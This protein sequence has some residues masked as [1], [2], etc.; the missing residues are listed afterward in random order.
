MAAALGQRREYTREQLVQLKKGKDEMNLAEFPIAA[1]SNRVSDSV[2]TLTFEEDVF[3]PETGGV[4]TRR[5]TVT[6]SDKYGLPTALDDEVIVGLLQLTKL[7]GFEKREVS[8]SRYELIG[9][10][11]WREEGRSYKRIDESLKR[12]LG[13]TLYYEKAWYDNEEKSWVDE[14]FHLLED[15]SLY[16]AERYRRRR[17]QQLPLPLSSFS[18]STVVFRSFQ[19]GFLKNLDL[20]VYLSLSTATAKRAYRFLDKR[21]Y[22]KR[23][24]EMDLKRFAFDRVGLS[25]SFEKHV[26]KTKEKLRPAIQEL[27]EIGFLVPMPEDQRYRK[28]RRGE[29]V[30]VLVRSDE[31]AK[32]VTATSGAGQGGLEKELADRGVTPLAA[33]ELVAGFPEQSVRQK[34]EVFDWIREQNRGQRMKNPGGYLAESIRKDYLPPDGFETKAE[35]TARKKAKAEKE[36]RLAAAEQKKKAEET[37]RWQSENRRVDAYLDSLSVVERETLEQTAMTSA[38]PFVRQMHDRARRDGDESSVERYRSTI[39]RN[40]VRQILAEREQGRADEK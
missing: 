18:W 20:D 26:G 13:V 27:E 3:D 11:R 5:L 35:R 16:D 9:V 23:R 29:W 7:R 38:A 30:I 17:N 25:R 12:W 15:L 10:L 22:H 14:H 28:I 2:K 24:F 21:F 4:A 33:R 1:L 40:H 31:L 34:I 32:K 39:I 8:F 36:Q 37:A 6:A 19:Q